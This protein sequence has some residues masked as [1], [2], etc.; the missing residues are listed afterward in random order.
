MQFELAPLYS[1]AVLSENAF[2]PKHSPPVAGGHEILIAF[3]YIS[4]EPPHVKARYKISRRFVKILLLGVCGFV[5]SALIK[6]FCELTSELEIYGL[7][8]F[9]RRGSETNRGPLENLGVKIFH[10]DTRCASDLEAIPP[11]DWVIDAAANP[12]VLAGADGKMSSRQL[13]EHNLIG[14]INLLEM[15]KERECGFSLLSTSRVYSIPALAELPLEVKDK[16]YT[17]KQGADLPI[18]ITEAGVSE[19]FSML[20]P[21]SFYGSS[22]FASEYLAL[23]Y[24]ETFTFPLWINRCG[25]L[26]G[27]GQFGRAD[28]G[29][30]SFWINVYLRDR[31]LA[32]L[33]F[34]GLGYQ[35]RDCLHPAD[36]ARLL[37]QQMRTSNSE[38][39]LLQNVSGGAA[40]AMSLAQLSDWCA[41]RFG[42]REIAKESTGRP[43]DLPWVVLD[44]TRA[45]QQWDWEPEI[46]RETILREIAVH[47]EAHPDWLEISGAI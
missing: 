11:V 28:Q 5:G 32:Y 2:Q 46:S 12:S 41:D 24:H 29:I 23:E 37:L 6:A 16:A 17:L 33:G 10:G 14:T 44:S 15:C 31:P 39:E 1:W 21:L 13:I 43:F 47:A 42:P 22:K 8:N 27:A 4:A 19:N 26:A 38:K 7:D 18:G 3:F 36:L 25:V 30:F 35:V 20:P 45:R 40:S 9:I 34:N